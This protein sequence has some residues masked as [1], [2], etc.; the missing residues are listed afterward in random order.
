MTDIKI[1]AL[2]ANVAVTPTADTIPIVHAAATEKITPK[3]LLDG[4][5]LSTGNMGFNTA[6][7]ASINY[8]FGG[9]IAGATTSY[10]IV[11]SGIVQ[12]GATSGAYGI[13]SQLGTQAATFTCGQLAQFTAS[14]GTF[15]AGSTVTNQYGFQVTSTMTGATNNYA[16]SAG[17]NSGAGRWN[18]YAG[19]SAPNYFLGDMQLGKT[20]TA[21]GTTGAQTISKT[22]GTV[23][24]AAAATSV[25]VTN[26]LVTTSSVITATVGTNDTTMKSVIAVAAAGSFTLF[27]NAAATAETRVNFHVFN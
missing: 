14:Q 21:G 22:I 20:V 6:V 16:F 9:S 15:G 8:S 10:G 19:G 26:T 12:S 11:E 4:T 23:N 13:R 2:P 25:V 3:Q 18:F 7:V 24:F 5:L 17:L 1:S 27:A